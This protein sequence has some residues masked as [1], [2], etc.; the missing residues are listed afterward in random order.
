[1]FSSEEIFVLELINDNA[2]IV[3]TAACVRRYV[4]VTSTGDR[5]RCEGVQ[6]VPRVRVGSSFKCFVA[7]W[8]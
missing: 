6:G 4:I 8:W 1:M 2:I 5:S 7:L 3:L